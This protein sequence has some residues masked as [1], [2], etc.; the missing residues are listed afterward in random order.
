MHARAW[1][2][3][4]HLL[5]LGP[6]RM[7]SCVCM[8]ARAWGLCA[9]LLHLGLGQLNQILR[10]LELVR[11]FDPRNRQ[12]AVVARAMLLDGG[13]EALAVLVVVGGGDRFD[14]RL[15]VRADDPTDRAIGRAVALEAG[16]EPCGVPVC[17]LEQERTEGCLGEPIELLSQ[18]AWERRVIGLFILARDLGVLR[19]R[20]GA[21]DVNRVLTHVLLQ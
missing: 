7:G 18:S 1:G 21:E 8:H 6:V 5:H 10:L 3:C 20:V 14:L 9:H 4:A 11:Q 15:V 12:S 17:G 19:G 16:L 2:L 13:W